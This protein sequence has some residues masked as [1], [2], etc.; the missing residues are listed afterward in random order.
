MI[1]DEFAAM[2][3]EPWILQTNLKKKM[4]ILC[5]P[6]LQSDRIVLHKIKTETGNKKEKKKEEKTSSFI[7]H[8]YRCL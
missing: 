5:L 2:V 8:S 3:G 7:H 4:L 6:K 1:T